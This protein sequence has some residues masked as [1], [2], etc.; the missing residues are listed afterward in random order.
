MTAISSMYNY[1]TS[2]LH[3][4]LQTFVDAVAAY[5]IENAPDLMSKEFEREGVKLHA[6]LMNSRFPVAIAKDA[7][8]REGRRAEGSW[9]RREP[10]PQKRKIPARQPFDATKIFRVCYY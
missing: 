5:V 4:R 9:R 1:S 3:W 2:H 6:T 7:A 10:E 8:E